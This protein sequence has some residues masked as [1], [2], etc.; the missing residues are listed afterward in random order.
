MRRMSFTLVSA[1]LAMVMNGCGTADQ[2]EENSAA[3]V[4]ALTSKDSHVAR[5]DE[6]ASEPLGEVDSYSTDTSRIPLDDTT[7]YTWCGACAIG[8]G[9]L[10]S[11]F[12]DGRACS[13]FVGSGQRRKLCHNRNS[14]TCAIQGC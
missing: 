7:S 11:Y 9:T 14:T 1:F 10:T 5:P 3:S 13:V 6:L 12:P 8:P 2:P 4:S